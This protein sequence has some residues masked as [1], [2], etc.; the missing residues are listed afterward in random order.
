MEMEH[1]SIVRAT[2]WLTATMG[3]FQSWARVR[4][5]TATLRSGPP[6]P[7]PVASHKHSQT[8][9]TPHHAH[10]HDPGRCMTTRPWA[11]TFRVGE[12]VNLL[13]GELGL[14]Q[15]IFHLRT[16]EEGHV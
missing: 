1:A 14:R 15:G 3:F 5:T 11:G 7:G 10:N 2:Q 12:R 16:K 9:N 8:L 4:T 13:R 6:M